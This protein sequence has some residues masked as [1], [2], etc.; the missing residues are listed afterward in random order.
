MEEEEQ[1]FKDVERRGNEDD[2][3]EIKVEVAE[4]G[5]ISGFL[6]SSICDEH[7]ASSWKGSCCSLGWPFS[8]EEMK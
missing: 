7:D 4:I 6:S 1:P 5:S 3:V 2:L 8:E